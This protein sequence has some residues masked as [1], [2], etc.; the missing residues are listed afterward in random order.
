MY[1]FSRNV[2]LGA[3]I[4]LQ[5]NRTCQLWNMTQLSYL[6]PSWTS[7]VHFKPELW[8]MLAFL[9]F[10]LA[11]KKPRK[12]YD[13]SML[14]SNDKI[15]FSQNYGIIPLSIY[16]RRSWPGNEAHTVGEKTKPFRQSRLG[17]NTWSYRSLVQTRFGITALVRT[18]YELLGFMP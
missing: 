7:L 17:F 14:N 11:N 18:W 8:W 12:V 10:D 5:C 16:W 1:L 2:R 6:P 15:K 13:L 4:P 9:W 3:G